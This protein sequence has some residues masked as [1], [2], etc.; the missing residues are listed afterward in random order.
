M[1]TEKKRINIT[2]D[3]KIYMQLSKIAL[4]AKK[5]IGTVTVDLLRESLAI[6]E[7]KYWSKEADS[8]LQTL[9]KVTLSHEEI[10]E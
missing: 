6:E 8:R 5:K 3:D 7:D 4:K 9:E 1:P 2:V 10:W